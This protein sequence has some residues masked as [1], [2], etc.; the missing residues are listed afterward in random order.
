MKNLLLLLTLSLFSTGVFA[1]EGGSPK[2][3]FEKT[4]HEFGTIEEGTMASYEF[5]FKN[6][7]DAALVLKNV[8]PSCG[9][10]T[11]EWPKKPIM[12]GEKAHIKAIYN[13]KGRPGRFHKSISVTTN[14]PD[15]PTIVLYIKGEVK[16]NAPTPQSPVK[17]NEQ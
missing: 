2:M 14:I 13:S 16:K 5:E 15:N 1:Q 3:E 9:C 7:G 4:S 12:P 17:I 6:T 10:T 11:P 8:K